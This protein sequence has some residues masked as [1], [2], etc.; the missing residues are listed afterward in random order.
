MKLTSPKALT[1]AVLS[2]AL[3]ATIFPTTAT[4]DGYSNW[5]TVYFTRHAEKQTVV[6]EVLD[7]NADEYTTDSDGNYVT[8]VKNDG[9]GAR[10][11]EVC[12]ADKCAEE[13]SDLGAIRAELLAKW[14]K[15]G[16][17]LRKLDAVYA[18]HKIRTQQ[19][20]TP[21][22][23]AAGLG[24]IQVP[25]YID[26]KA[27]TELNP[28]KTTLSECATLEAIDNAHAN[29]F[30]TILV[31]GHSG[32]LYDI[33]GEG[34]KDCSISD[35]SISNGLGLDISDDDRFPKN[36]DD[37][38]VRDY[39]DIWKIDIS[40]SGTASFSYRK[41]LQPTPSLKQLRVVN[42]AN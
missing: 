32:T 7:A 10:F 26:G 3:V 34:V 4:A 29:G 2:A 13:L 17:I 36:D 27:A 19:T 15:R 30:D 41:N 42:I 18:T 25:A 21:T 8:V 31:A 16:N 1:S 37:G 14:F 11:D 38:K 40:P 22:A 33:M 20:V 9:T 12:G 24:F 35:G 39:G 5:L 6:I 28:E 23:E